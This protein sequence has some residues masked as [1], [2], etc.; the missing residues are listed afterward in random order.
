MERLLPMATVRPFFLGCL[1]WSLTPLL[2]GVAGPQAGLQAK[3]VPCQDHAVAARQGPLWLLYA[4]ARR[5]RLV[6]GGRSCAFHSLP[7]LCVARPW[8][9]EA[10]EIAA[11]T[12]FLDEEAP[13]ERAT[14]AQ[15][16]QIYCALLEVGSSGDKWEAVDHSPALGAQ[17]PHSVSAPLR[18]AR[19][20]GPYGL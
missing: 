11:R 5:I 4:S 15:A 12:V 14:K 7:H 17:T 10:E 19:L 9:E 13:E 1:W 2:P 18:P 8:F 16:L 6:R 3:E 20:E